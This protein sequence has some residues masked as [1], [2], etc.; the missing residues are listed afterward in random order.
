MSLALR[1]QNAWNEVFRFVAE[2]N[3]IIG[4]D[5]SKWRPIKVE[6]DVADPMALK[7]IVASTQ[8]EIVSGYLTLNYKAA[9]LGKLVNVFGDLTK[10]P[11][12][13]FWSD[14]GASRKLSDIINIMNN[15]LGL[16]L[17]ISGLYTDLEDQTFTVPA[18]NGSVILTLSPKVI[19][20]GGSSIMPMRLAESKKAVIEVFNRGSHIGTAITNKAV[21]PYKSETGE[22]VWNGETQ[23]VDAPTMSYLPLLA[24]LDFT[25]LFGT[26]QLLNAAFNAGNRDFG[27]G[28]WAAVMNDETRAIVNA[29]LATVGIPPIDR[30]TNVVDSVTSY[31]NMIVSATTMT[32][33]TA[34]DRGTFVDLTKPF[35]GRH[36]SYFSTAGDRAGKLPAWINDNVKKKYAIRIQPPGAT[37][38]NG[39]DSALEEYNIAH[40]KKP[41]NK[42]P[43]YLFFND[44]V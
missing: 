20:V 43:L 31:K 33:P 8:Q 1:E 29:R 19:P 22:L 11:M 10:P 32:A 25:D 23:L 44:L 4:D 26:P 15:A 39:W 9:D 35:Q 2:S 6:K 17:N 27:S 30:P 21:T 12:V 36:F 3:P 7:L 38:I 13:K 5:P 14:A 24:Q 37:Y 28:G 34:N 16:Q 40:D 41:M 18:K 42:R